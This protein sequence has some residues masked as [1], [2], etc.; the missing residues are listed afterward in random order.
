MSNPYDI[1]VGDHL[2]LDVT[3]P[4]IF[5]EIAWTNLFAARVRVL[6]LSWILTTDANVGDRWLAL[7]IHRVAAVWRIGGYGHVIAPSQ[8]TYTV[9][10]PG[11]SV[12]FAI[13]TNHIDIA[14]PG[15]LILEPGDAIFTRT[16]NI[17]A[18]DQHTNGHSSCLVLPRGT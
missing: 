8:I 13:D 7:E 15:L 17:Q 11:P 12:T 2:P 4:A 14:I 5:T 6:W 9:A 3:A 1:N 16:Q 18:G 10:M